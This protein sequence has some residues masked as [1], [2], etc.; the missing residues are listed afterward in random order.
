MGNEMGNNNTS[1]I[2]EEDNIGEAEKKGFQGDTN[3]TSIAKDVEEKASID[4]TNE[5]G[6]DTWQDEGHGEDVKGKAQTITTDEDSQEKTIGF[7][8]NH[9]T[10]VLENDSMKGDTRASDV[11]MENQ[12]PPTAEAEVVQEIGEAA[13][14]S[15]DATTE[16][17][18]VTMQED[19]HDDRMKE[20]MQM[21]PS[22]EAKDVQEGE[23]EAFQ[24][25]VTGLNSNNT[26]ST[27][28]NDLLEED[29]CKNDLNM[30]NKIHPTAEVED[31]QEK[32]TGMTSHYSISS[33]KNDLL[34]EDDPEDDV[35]V[36]HQKHKTIDDKFDQL[37]IETRLNFDDET[38]EFDD[39]TTQE[40][41]QDANAVKPTVN[42]I[43]VQ[44]K[45]IISASDAALKLTNSFEG[46]GDEI[47]E[48]RQPE[49]SP[50]DGSVEAK[51]GKSENLSS[52]SLEGTEE[53]EK[54][55]TCFR[56]HWIETCNHHLNNEPSI[57]Q[58]DEITEVRQPEMSLIDRS[59]VTESGNLEILSSSSLED[60]QEFVKQ[61][62]TREREHMLV[63]DNHDLNSDPS[64]QQGDE[65]SDFRQP[66][67][68][69]ND[70]AVEAKG[71]NSESFSSFEDTEEYE[72]QEETCLREHLLV[73][74]NEPSIQQGG[75]VIEVGQSDTSNDGS[76]EAKATN[77]EILSSSSLEGTEEYEKQEESC[78]REEILLT[79]N[80]QLN[81]E[82]P[83]QQD[84]EETTVLTLSAVNMSNDIEI[85]ESSGHSDNDEPDKFL[86]EQSFVGTDSL[87]E[88]NLL[89]TNSHSEQIKDDDLA[90]EMKSHVELCTDMLD[91][92]S[93]SLSIDTTING[94]SLTKVKCTTEDSQTSPL[95][96]SIVVSP[97]ELDHEEN[98]KVPHGESILSRS[99]SMENSQDCKPDQCMKDSLKE[100][101]M[102]YICDV[103]VES[104]GDCN[105]ERNMLLDSNVS[106][107]VTNDQV[108]EPKVTEN[109]VPF[110]DFINNSNKTSE[111]TGA[112]S[113]EKH[114]VVP[115]AKKISLIEGLTDVDCRHEEGNENKIE[116]TNQNPEISHVLV[117]TF[118]GTEMSEHCNCDLVTINQE[119]SFPLKNNSSLLHFYDDH[120]D[121]VKQDKSFT[122]TSMPNLG[123]KQ[124]NK[125]R[126]S[127]HTIDNSNSSELTVPSLNLDDKEA[128]E[129]EGKEDPQ[130][131]E[132]ELTA[133]TATMSS[134]APYS[135]K[136]IFENGGYET[137]ESITRLST[138]SNPDNPNT[139]SQ[140]QK[141]P[142][143]N[144]NLRKEARPGESDKI[145]LL[146]QNKS[147]NES[148]SKQTSLNLINSMPHA[149]YEQCM[150]H[151]EE[152]PVEEKIVTMERSYSR[153]SKAPFIGLLKEEE[154]AHLLGMSRI[155]ENHAGTKNTVS[156]TSPK[157]DKRKTR[158]SFFSSCMCCATVP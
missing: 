118:E 53:Y 30:E 13:L 115:Q 45:T 88:H 37:Q 35:N 84:V 157:K 58:G 81:N 151:S 143:F 3:E 137:R 147:A 73:A 110:D 124:T 46:S 55:E 102:V 51:V 128:F 15:E 2:K 31:V 12:T 156:S 134:I 93:D 91:T 145:P 65:I 48:V 107:L 38:S 138:E 7:A 150:L 41:K 96:S 113:E 85:Q 43:D 66:E 116:E 90:K 103:S 9:A 120:Q 49:K 57:Q 32:A 129:K 99:G 121:N 141:S 74:Y 125:T 28:E 87:L 109:G 131:T 114:Y 75:V 146:H 67:K 144:L 71:G 139:S 24:D 14:V 72:K 101:N 117:N 89:D 19:N 36:N 155:Q 4:I 42:S 18:K 76:V 16:L 61:E 1:T 39:K 79:Y 127:G 119:E 142:S 133:S 92:T 158:S 80:H 148:F 149:Q 154:E 69:P 132:A 83:I 77:S 135:N 34:E 105:G 97:I 44:E 130:H 123:C 63:T 62:E 104:N 78:L 56:E 33:L 122:A 52:L 17:G 153:K 82:P 95:E 94:N 40:D 152:M 22:D 6:K 126:N 60:T 50:S 8:S 108:E 26:E 136:S 20:N 98:C 106:K 112:T 70:E 25:E 47:T 27:L 5:P 11:N 54:Q 59:V 21:I 23:A 29:T 64:I 86:S 100:Y 68:S 10:T 140:M 111:E